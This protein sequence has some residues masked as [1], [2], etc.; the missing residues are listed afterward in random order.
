MSIKLY[1]FAP[2]DRSG[3][4]RWTLEELSIPYELKILDWEKKEHKT[5]EYLNIH[6][7]GAVPALVDEEIT[8][9]ESGAIVLYLADKYRKKIS[10]SPMVDEATR[11]EYLKWVLFAAATLDPKLVKIFEYQKLE[12]E[13]E[14]EKMAKMNEL[15]SDCEILFKTLNRIL[16]NNK[17]IVGNTFSAADIML[18]Q[19]LLWAKNAELLKNHLNIENYLLE[20]ENRPAAIKSL[21]FSPEN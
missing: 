1:G 17:F 7:M 19:P 10:L 8:L 3:R 9:F 21:I 12:N 2:Q 20:L 6:P 13:N 11:P 18:A 15:Y 16:E 5:P 4:V 14:N